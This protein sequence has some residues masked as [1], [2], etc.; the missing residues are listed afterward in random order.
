MD[1]DLHFDIPLSFAIPLVVVCLFLAAYLS[2][3]ETAITGASRPRMHRLAQQGHP[4]AVVVNALLDRK[5]ETVSAVLPFIVADVVRLGL[6]MAFPALALATVR[7]L[8]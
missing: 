8:T 6:V 1:A 3:A 4:R 5:D 7:L 2:A